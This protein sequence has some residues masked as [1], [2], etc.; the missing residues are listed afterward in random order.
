MMLVIKSKKIVYNPYIEK[1]LEKTTPSNRTTRNPFS[2]IKA[3]SLDEKKM[4]AK[5]YHIFRR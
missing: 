1:M 5:M 4:E 3:T 2:G